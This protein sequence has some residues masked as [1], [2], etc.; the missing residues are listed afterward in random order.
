MQYHAAGK[1]L[2]WMALLTQKLCRPGN[3]VL[4]ANASVGRNNWLWKLASA[5]DMNKIINKIMKRIGRA[6]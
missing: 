1:A 5:H 2:R 3:S 6:S 4:T